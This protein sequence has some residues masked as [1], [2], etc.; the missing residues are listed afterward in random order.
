LRHSADVGGSTALR[1]TG[2]QF[3]S[4]TYGSEQSHSCFKLSKGH[5]VY[6]NYA[7]LAYWEPWVQFPVCPF[8]AE[9]LPGVLVLY[10]EP[11]LIRLC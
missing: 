10:Q 4:H 6:W 8:L 11:T 5:M 1:N 3:R 9:R 7:R 2:L